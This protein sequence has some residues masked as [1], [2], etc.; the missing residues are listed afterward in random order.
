MKLR[1]ALKNK[2]KFVDNELT[3]ASIDKMIK[4]RLRKDRERTK[5]LYGGKLKAPTEYT[6][7][8]WDAIKKHWDLPNP[9]MQSKRMAETRKK[10][11]Y[12]PRVGRHGYA[13]RK[14]NLVS[15]DIISHVSNYFSSRPACVDLRLIFRLRET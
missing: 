4:V 2:F 10:V 14:A 13:R 1:K 9:K 11:V 5:R 6:E 12:N 8:E 15:V 7:K 3:D